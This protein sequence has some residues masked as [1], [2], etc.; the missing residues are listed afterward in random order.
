MIKHDQIFR[1][2]FSNSIG[3]GRLVERLSN[4]EQSKFPPYNISQEDDQIF[5]EM[6]VAGYKKDNVSVVV[7]DGILVIEGASE[8]K[9]R[10]FKHK[11][12]STK[13][14]KRSFSLG[15]YV[16]VK[17]AELKDGILTISLEEVLPP[18]KQPT[19]IDIK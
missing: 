7:E 8:K 1:D 13:R 19:V 2:F 4:A 10:D 15:E 6:A 12:I 5:V 3:M 18:E 17:S 14:F 9:P 16:E 11:G